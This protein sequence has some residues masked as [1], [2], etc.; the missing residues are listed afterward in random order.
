LQ[1]EIALMQSSYLK[2]VLLEESPTFTTLRDCL[3]ALILTP[4]E[5]V[6]RHAALVRSTDKHDNAQ[7]TYLSGTTAYTFE[8]SKQRRLGDDKALVRVYCSLSPDAIAARNA[9]ARAASAHSTP[10]AAARD[11]QQKGT[12]PASS[13]AKPA[14]PHAHAASSSP[15]PVAAAMPPVTPSAAAATR[16]ALAQVGASSQSP[17][18]PAQANALDIKKQQ[19]AGLHLKSPGLS[20]SH[21]PAASLAGPQTSS[22]FSG[23]R[24][25]A[26]S[27]VAGPALSASLAPSLT[28][29]SQPPQS[30]TAS[31]ARPAA[32]IHT[33]G[34]SAATDAA[35]EISSD[36]GDSLYC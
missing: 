22:L 18:P 28:A 19:G 21:V 29:P 36:D 15:R 25:E 27:R 24:Q 3:R 23:T 10:S 9:A 26:S 6:A 33:R 4:P 16:A 2:A 31:P 14:A 1:S 35:G 8:C 34:A 30:S 12:R 20:S 7:V 5:L 13:P 11:E 32:S 17:P